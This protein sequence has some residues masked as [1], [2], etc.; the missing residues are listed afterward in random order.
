MDRSSHPSRSASRDDESRMEFPLRPLVIIPTYNE[1]DNIAQLI[2]TVLGTDGRFHLLIVDDNSPDNTGKMVLEM[3]PNQY[4]DRLFLLSR[5]GKEGLGSAYIT[6]FKWGL[7]Q[8][9]DFMIQ[10]DGD[11]SHNPQDLK[12]MLQNARHFDFVIASRYIQGGGTA[13]WDWSRKLLSRSA[14]IYTRWILKSEITDFT[15]GYNGWSHK[16]LNS[17][18]LNSIHSNGYSFQIELKYLAQK[19][20]YRHTEIPITFTERRSGKSKMSFLIALEA[21]WRVWQ[22]RLHWEKGRYGIKLPNQ[23]QS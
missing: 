16:I 7:A 19:L 11:W 17:L 6:G 14:G 3:K 21:V 5:P 2:P 1:R 23:K 18:D 20:G 10:M 12:R 22:F 9:Y 15:G 4:P 13:N 8:Q